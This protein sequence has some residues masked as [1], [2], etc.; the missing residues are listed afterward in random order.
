MSRIRGHDG[1]HDLW[2]ISHKPTEYTE[3]VNRT[4]FTEESR[5]DGVEGTQMHLMS[6]ASQPGGEIWPIWH[7][8][9]S[10]WYMLCKG[11][12]RGWRYTTRDK[13]NELQERR[14]D[15]SQFQN[16][17]WHEAT[18]WLAKPTNWR[19]RQL[20]GR[21]RVITP[22]SPPTPETSQFARAQANLSRQKVNSPHQLDLLAQMAFSLLGFLSPEHLHESDAY[23]RYLL[24]R[25]NPQA[26]DLA[27]EWCDLGALAIYLGA[28]LVEKAELEASEPQTLRIV[29][30][31]TVI[32]GC[33]SVYEEAAVFIDGIV[34]RVSPETLSRYPLIG[35][36][37]RL[38]RIEQLDN[39]L[40][41]FCIGDSAALTPEKISRFQSLR[42]NELLGPQPSQLSFEDN[43]DDVNAVAQG[44][45]TR[46]LTQYLDFL[47]EFFTL[48]TPTPI[49]KC[50]RWAHVLHRDVPWIDV[51]PQLQH[52]VFEAILSQ[53]R[54]I[55]IPGRRYEAAEV[56]FCGQLWSA[57]IL[58]HL[59]QS[60]QR[61]E[62]DLSGIQLP[63]LRIILEA[64]DLY[65]DAAD[66]QGETTET[67]RYRKLNTRNS[68][69]LRAAVL[70]EIDKEE[71]RLKESIVEPE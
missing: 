61:V 46:L 68:E 70:E 39:D 66:S 52:R 6:L 34:D 17:A 11:E 49:K 47:V 42:Q 67:H 63:C 24:E 62:Y 14:I 54:A 22:K 30:A 20:A 13:W 44:L 37:H 25:G 18:N 35:A 29:H 38:R 21:G 57:R 59:W 71:S 8:Y 45:R 5:R 10:T 50:I 27:L 64:L 58:P 43:I 16:W 32:T 53:C 19:A 51:D 55:L 36:V 3:R 56:D 7:G 4:H 26:V 12:V 48:P 33:L 41:P 65:H 9:Y 1:L 15:A 28:Q 2:G 40:R 69:P 23:S 31:I 60:M